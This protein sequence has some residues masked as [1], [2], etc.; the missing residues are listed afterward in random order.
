M[1]D[2]GAGLRARWTVIGARWTVICAALAGVAALAGCSS[3]KPSASPPTGATTTTGGTA[4]ATTTTA[5]G[6]TTTTAPS[7]CPGSAFALTV[8][9]SQGAA[10]TFEYSFGLRNTTSGPCALTGY[11][12]IQ[13]LGAGGTKLTTHTVDGGGQSF[14]A[15]AP[16][17]VNLTPGATGYFNM[18]FSD[19]PTGSET[20][21]PTATALQA[22]PP[23][24]S[25]PLQVSGQFT[26]CDGGTV[27]VS[28]VFGPGSPETQTTAPPV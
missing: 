3:T 25:T 1:T 20:S 2:E 24:T 23:G 9:G 16:G 10:G 15:F 19:V 26:V 21:C 17:P 7:G 22:T 28:P 8:V 14:T 4:P 27:H 6:A 13:L 5:P 11:P 18:G 12:D